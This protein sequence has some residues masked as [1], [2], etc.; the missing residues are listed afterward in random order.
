VPRV[1]SDRT[2]AV[3][4]ALTPGQSVTLLIDAVDDLTATVLT[5]TVYSPGGRLIFTAELDLRT[6]ATDPDDP[7]RF[8]Q[9][10]YPQASA[11]D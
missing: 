8:P 10:S 3:L 1:P 4:A 11:V 9:A 6:V 7:H 5:R 2:R